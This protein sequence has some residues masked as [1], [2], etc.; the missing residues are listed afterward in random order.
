MNSDPKKTTTTSNTQ[1]SATSTPL[2]E[3]APMFSDIWAKAGTAGANAPTDWVAQAN[4]T[5][6]DALGLMKSIAPTL[7]SNAGSLRDMASKVAS[8]YFL[9][10]N[11]DPNFQASAAAAIKPITQQLTE[12]VLPQITDASI[13][14]GGVGGG[15]AAYGGSRQDIQENQAVRNW[16]QTA[17]DITSKM[18]S[19]AY[20]N[21]LKL[22][23]Y[24]AG[25]DQAATTAA[26]Q[27]SMTLG[28]AGT[29][30]Q[31]YAQQGLDNTTKAWLMALQGA[32]SGANVLTTGGFG[33]KSQTSNSSSETVQPAPDMATQ[34]L[35]GI[36]G[37]LGIMSSL[38]TGNPLGAMAG[39]GSIFGGGGTP[40]G[41]TY[42][43]QSGGWGSYGGIPFPTF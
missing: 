35:Q 33:N 7:S 11:A 12:S 38:A 27:P 10:P 25:M 41:A 5:Q 30:E 21:G 43:A 32:Q 31:T 34:W 23:P 1:Q 39:L 36:T 16:S 22:M 17:G 19:D 28:Q 20:T 26:L 9:N 40:T 37:G 15:P 42:G 13:R 2:A 4:P 14:N 29:Q 6:Y 24:A 3:T 18:A 8:G